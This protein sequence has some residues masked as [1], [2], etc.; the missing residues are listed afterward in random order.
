MIVGTLPREVRQGIT[1][2]RT[3]LNVSTAHLLRET[4]PTATN[5]QI[6]RGETASAKQSK[7]NISGVMSRST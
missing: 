6:T 4:I 5:T 3:R 7:W 2:S 1:N